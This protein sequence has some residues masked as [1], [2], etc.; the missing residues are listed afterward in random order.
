MRI[1][2]LLFYFSCEASDNEDDDDDEQANPASGAKGTF[3]R[4]YRGVV[5][6]KKYRI[7]Q[8]KDHED[9]QS[10]S[11][12][13]NINHEPRSAE[14]KINSNEDIASLNLRLTSSSAS[15]RIEH[16]AMTFTGEDV[17]QQ[18][19]NKQDDDDEQ[20]NDENQLII[21]DET[22]DFREDEHDDDDYLSD[23]SHASDDF[24]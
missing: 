4:D 14:T 2:R 15:G 5:H 13:D 11:D 22:S 12:Y 1:I 18:E 10:L 9:K 19:L 3:E 21:M 17:D 8:V 24:K 20:V 7:I 6:V 23:H 16:N